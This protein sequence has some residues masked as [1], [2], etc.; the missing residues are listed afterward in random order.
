MVMNSSQNTVVPDV[1]A[2][3]MWNGFICGSR[4]Y[5]RVNVKWVYLWFQM[6]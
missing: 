1:I 3:W 2:E 6:L 4:C 5:S